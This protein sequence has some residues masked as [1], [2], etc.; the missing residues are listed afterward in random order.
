M[1]EIARNKTNHQILWSRRLSRL[2]ALIV[3][4]FIVAFAASRAARDW[5]EI[6]DPDRWLRFAMSCY[7]GWS[8]SCR[9]D[10]CEDVC[11]ILHESHSDPGVRARVRFRPRTMLTAGLVATSSLAGPWNTML[12]AVRRYLR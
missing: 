10:A 2:L 4:A 9:V 7:I 12:A 11:Y 1:V 8:P 3:R 6:V 5:V